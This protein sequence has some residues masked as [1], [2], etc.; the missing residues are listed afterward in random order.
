MNILLINHYAGAGKYG[1]EY[2]P[3]YLA[4]EWVKM[5]HTVTIAA[6]SYSHVRS[7]PIAVEGTYKEEVIEGIRYVWLK[8]PEYSGNSIWRIVNMMT[9]VTRLFSHASA[10]VRGQKPDIVIA[11]STYPLDIFPAYRIALKYGAKLVFEVHDLWPL[12]PILLGGYSRSHPFILALQGAEDF[13]Y[14]KSHLVVSLLQKADTYMKSRGMDAHKFT[15]IPNGVDLDE[16]ENSKEALPEACERQLA[17]CKDQGL[18]LMG[19]AGAHG[20]ANSLDTL[21][22]AAERLRDEPVRVILLG[23]GPDRMRLEQIAA[24]KKLSN[25]SFWGVMPKQLIPTLLRRMDALY[26]GLKKGP[27]FQFGISPNKLLDYMMAGKPVIQAID[28]GNDM[29]LESGCGFTVPPGDP[30]AIA[31]AVKRL[32]AL[33]NPDLKQ[34]GA[35]GRDFVISHHDYRILA[36]RF[37]DAT[38]NVGSLRD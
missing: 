22:D 11:S 18:F 1:M 16:W 27:L 23:D 38:E 24:E 19:Y 14:R 9:F 32:L 7:V 25:V 20:L 3:Y 26:I 30:E 28:A 34:M 36:Q 21:L 10:L 35:R 6:A 2:R 13:A 12:S 29:V 17:Q 5:G 15:H 37:V 8:T 4:R 33:P 31:I